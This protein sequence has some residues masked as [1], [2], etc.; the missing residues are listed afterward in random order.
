[1]KKRLRKLSGFLITRFGILRFVFT[2]DTDNVILI[3]KKMYTTWRRLGGVGFHI[4]HE[5]CKVKKKICVC[6]KISSQKLLV[7]ARNFFYNIIK[8]F[9]IIGGFSHCII[10]ATYALTR[11]A[12]KPR[13][14]DTVRPSSA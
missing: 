4:V 8:L 9:V 12:G 5:R 14:M 11:N 6:G 10:P 3:F 7:Q 13:I 2:L 1:M